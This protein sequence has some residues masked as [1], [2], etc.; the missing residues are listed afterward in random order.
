[1]NFKLK[2][3]ALLLVVMMMF[4]S[5]S[6]SLE[7]VKEFIPG[8]GGQTTQT[9]KAPIKKTT[10]TTTT[11]KV[12]PVEPKWTR[13]DHSTSR[14]ELLAQYTLTTEEIEATKALLDQMVVGAMPDPEGDPNVAVMTSEEWDALYEQ[15]EDAFYNI[16]QQMTIATI[17]YYCNM[18]D[19]AANERYLGTRDMF[20][21]IQDKYNESLRELYL[22]SPMR[23]ELFEGW[24]EQEIQDMLEYDPE[25]MAVKKVIGNL[26]LRIPAGRATAGPPVGSTL[27][28][29]GLNMMDFINFGNTLCIKPCYY[30]RS[31]AS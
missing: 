14:N 7:A 27:G 20:Y 16:A 2:L 26:K 28:Q 6:V 13:G 3:L 1:M 19:E 21:E 8:L 5:C 22:N 30:Q 15:F 23:D 9:T 17:I 25:I 31:A 12:E 4:T 24:S 29:W 10:T 18:S 11:G